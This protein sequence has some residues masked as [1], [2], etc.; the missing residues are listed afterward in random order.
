MWS[1][2]SLVLFILIGQISANPD[3]Q[4]DDRLRSELETAAEDSAQLADDLA[5]ML[6]RLELGD[7]TR[8]IEDDIEILEDDYQV[9]SALDEM[10]ARIEKLS[11]DTEE[12][13]LNGGDVSEDNLEKEEELR[14]TLLELED[15]A[16]EIELVAGNSASKADAAAIEKMALALKE[17]SA[18]INLSKNK[19]KSSSNKKPRKPKA[20]SGDD[21]EEDN[22]KKTAR[23][24]KNPKN[25]KHRDEILSFL[26]KGASARLEL[27]QKSSSSNKKSRTQKPRKSKQYD[28]DYEG[29][30]YDYDQEEESDSGVDD[31]DLSELFEEVELISNTDE[32]EDD[33]EDYEDSDASVEDNDNDSEEKKSLPLSDDA[34]GKSGGG[35]KKP[36]VEEPVEECADKQQLDRVQICKPSF[37]N[38]DSYLEFYTKK[39]QESQYCFNVT[40]TVCEEKMQTVSKEVCTYEYQQKEVIAPARIIDLGYERNFKS[41]PVTHCEKKHIKDGYKE[42]EVESCYLEGVE[43]PYRLPSVTAN[44]HDFIELAAPVPEKKCRLFRYDVPEI[45]CK[46]EVNKEC[47]TLLSLAPDHVRAPVSLVVDQPRGDCQHRNLEQKTKVCMI[48]KKIKVPK[49]NNRPSYGQYSGGYR[50]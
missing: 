32:S 14:E 33:Y 46:D 40:R 41:F 37:K 49:Y 2:G 8:E 20:D 30:D 16:K 6:A 36:E 17:V 38:R 31:S 15:V 21:S 4:F 19:K 26:G 10:I 35:Y 24:R 43:I 18:K 44:I 23:R 1:A 47:V 5:A 13:L 34:E 12:K 28:D 50:Y 27:K 42:K 39:P 22:E 9:E 7:D 45:V 11:A 3:P 25:F 29:D 48:E